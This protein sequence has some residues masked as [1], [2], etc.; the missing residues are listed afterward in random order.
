MYEKKANKSHPNVCLGNNFMI[1]FTG[2]IAFKLFS[3]INTRYFSKIKKN[4]YKE[5]K[6]IFS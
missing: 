6:I 5:I 3:T 4:Y 2:N 1:K